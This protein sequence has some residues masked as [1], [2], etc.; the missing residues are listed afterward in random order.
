MLHSLSSIFI[1]ISRCPWGRSPAL[2]QPIFPKGLEGEGLDPPQFKVTVVA[3]ELS[4][5]VC[6]SHL[7]RLRDPGS[8]FYFLGFAP[9]I[10]LLSQEYPQG[11]E[12]SKNGCSQP[13][14]GVVLEN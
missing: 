3:Q 11:G 1:R 2:P 6:E 4:Q 7:I 12:G 10:L 8:W 14:G 13:P 9:P 5:Q